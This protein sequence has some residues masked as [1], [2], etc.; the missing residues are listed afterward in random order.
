MGFEWFRSYH[1]APT[2]P[3]W[4]VIAK[5]AGVRF[6]DVAAIVWALFDYAS[7]HSERG[8]IDGFDAE[9]LALTFDYEE[10]QIIA[11]IDALHAKNVLQDN[12][13][14]NWRK[15]QPKREDDSAGRVRRHRERDVTQ[16]NADVTQGNGREEESREEE[17]I[18]VP[19]GTDASAAS[20]DPPSPVEPVKPDPVAADPKTIVFGDV[21]TWLRSLSGKSEQSI[22][23]FLGKCCAEYGDGNVIVAVSR[24]RSRDPP[25]DPFSALKA[26]LEAMRGKGNGKSGRTK[27]SADEQRERRRAALVAAALAR[28]VG[29]GGSGAGPEIT[30]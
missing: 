7:Q 24:L 19:S 8:S 23:S 2:D 20:E 27:E 18:S 16:R 10:A 28:D 4:K 30:A 3:K 5:R 1:G 12:A 21:L 14:V 9:T 26:E 17:S 13:F 15:R 22:R 11:V 25:V 6:G 29:S